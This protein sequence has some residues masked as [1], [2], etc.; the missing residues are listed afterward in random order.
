MNNEHKEVA[1]SILAIITPVI[2]DEIQTTVN[3]KID[4]LNTKLDS[5]ID[6][7]KPILDLIEGS[8]VARRIVLWVTSIILAVGATITMFKNIW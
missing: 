4:R 7:I 3:G 2:R 8:V 5:H 6:E 1:E